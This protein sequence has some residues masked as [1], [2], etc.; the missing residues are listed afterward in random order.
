MSEKLEQMRANLHAKL[1]AVVDQ[2]KTAKANLENAPKEAEADI[3]AKLEAA[4][5]NFEAKKQEVDAAKAHIKELVEAKKNDIEEQVE[6]WKAKRE[7]DKLAKR[8]E[9]AEEY[10]EA[11]IV[12][13]LASAVEADRAVLEAAVAR[14]DAE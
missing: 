5:T 2:L 12:V 1:D 7:H 10:A 9:R 8:A 11:C 4:K 14:K 13:A 6:Q 3:R